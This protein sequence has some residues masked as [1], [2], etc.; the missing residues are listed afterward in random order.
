[1]PANVAMPGEW[2]GS[3]NIWQLRTAALLWSKQLGA[4]GR[5]ANPAAPFP[6]PF[7]LPCRTGLCC[8]QSTCPPDRLEKATIIQS[9]AGVSHCSPL[10]SSLWPT[11]QPRVP[12][13]EAQVFVSVVWTMD[14][15]L[16]QVKTAKSPS[17]HTWCR[18]LQRILRD[19]HAPSWP[20]ASGVSYSTL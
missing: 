11:L 17:Y 14:R 4:Q 19:V 9:S 1:L 7:Q 20:G 3:V 2:V 10:G 5:C 6:R 12:K 16:D 8:A 15:Q 13:P 18:A